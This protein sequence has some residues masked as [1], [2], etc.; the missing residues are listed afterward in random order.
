MAQTFEVAEGVYGIDIELWDT[1]VLAAYLFDGEEATLIETGTAAGLN[2]LVEGLIDLGVHPSDLTNA[3]ISHIHIDHSGGA[4]GLVDRNPD[5]NVYIHESSAA[6]LVDP[7]RL[8][9]S[10]KRVMG[11]HFWSMGAPHS[12]PESNLV[13]V[14]D[15]GITIDTSTRSLEVVHVPGHSPDHL[16]VLDGESNIL[17]ANESIGSYFPKSD[18]WLPPATLPNFDI[19]AVE[20]SIE[21][22][23]SLAPEKVVFSHFGSWDG[24]PEVAFDTAETRLE[25]F[26]ERILELYERYGDVDETIDAVREDLLQF[27]PNYDPSVE[28]FYAPLVTHGYLRHHGLL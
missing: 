13:R 27:D 10:S 5:L 8:A 28:S 1:E 24:T 18:F 6:H 22:L 9:E 21:T 12:L 26:D 14:P 2:T 19:D 4:A 23:R 7:N 3:V 17:F 25:A 15:A 16:A 20:A 11:E